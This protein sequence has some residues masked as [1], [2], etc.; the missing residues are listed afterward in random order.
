[1]TKF[2]L[3]LRKYKYILVTCNGNNIATLKNNRLNVLYMHIFMYIF[4]NIVYINDNKI[5]RDE[6]SS[7]EREKMETKVREQIHF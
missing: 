1:M 6:N 5:K 7:H 4:R 3:K 2:Y